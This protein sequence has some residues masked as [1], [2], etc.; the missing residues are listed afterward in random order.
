MKLNQIWC[1]IYWHEWGVQRQTFFLSHP[2]ALGR[3]QK[4][5]YHLISITK[6]ISKIFYTKLC[7]CSHKWKI[8]NISD[9]IFILSP[10]LC[11]GGGT[12][13][14]PGGQIKKIFKHGH[15]VFHINGDNEQNR[16]QVKFS[17]CQF[18]RFYTKLCVCSHKY[19]LERAVDGAPLQIPTLKFLLPQHPEVP[20]Q[21]MTLATEWKFCSIC[22]LYFICE[23]TYKVWY[24]NLWNW[25]VNDIWPFDLA[26][27]S[28][29]WP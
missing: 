7:V 6:S 19:K 5:K 10:G 18:Q 17:S 11:P 23:N 2:G 9:G 24:K 27:R 13:G 4:V 28:P 12:L 26:P 21:G 25:H 16:M 14:C 22:F 1:V 8:Q 15:V 29:V 3:G 20:P